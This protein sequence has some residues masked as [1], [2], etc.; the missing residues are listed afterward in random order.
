MA[1]NKKILIDI[2]ANTS[3]FVSEL[4]DVNRVLSNVSS[5]FS[6][7]SS[8]IDSGFTDL[9]QSAS[10][11]NRTLSSMESVLHKL[12]VEI[13]QLNTVS[14]NSAGAINNFSSATG[15]VSKNVSSANTALNAFMKNMSPNQI[16]QSVAAV[17]SM[18]NA[19]SRLGNILPPVGRAFQWNFAYDL[20]HLPG[21]MIGAASRSIGNTIRETQQLEGEIYDL[22]AFLGGVGG[23]ELIDFSKSL[24]FTGT[25]EELIDKGL[26]QLQHKILSVGQESTFTALQ[27]A[28]ATTEAAKAGVSI[29]EIA[30][31][32]GTALDAINLLAQNTGESLESSATSLSKLQN[33]FENSL[34]KTQIGFGQAA[35]SG[36]QFQII[37]DGLATADASASAT[38]S[39]LTQ[40]L[41]NVGGSAQ[42]L[43]MSFF[44]TVSLVA[45]MV[46]AFESAASAGTSLKY[47]FSALSG[48]RSVKAQGALKKLGLMDEYGQTVFFDEKGF[49]GL[50]FM[51]HQLREAFDDSSG[52]AVDVRN[53]LITDIFGQDALKAVSRLVSM[54]EE[55]TSEMLEMASQ[56]KANAEAGTQSAKEV[57][58][59]KNEGLDYDLE[60][61][62]GTIDSLGKTLA[63]PT[64]KPMSNVV[65]TAT[66]LANAAFDVIT[67]TKTIEQ[68]IQEYLG[69]EV[70]TKSL[71]PG[72]E[73]ILKMVVNYAGGLG[74]MLKAVEEQGWNMQT[75]GTAVA[76]L[77]G[78]PVADIEER[79]K[80][81]TQYFHQLYT[82]I[83]AFIIDL[84]DTIAMIGD[85]I[86]WAFDGIMKA[87]S[88][89]QTNWDSIV[90]GVKKFA[91]AWAIFQGIQI[92]S[93]I[94]ALTSGLATL[95][96]TIG[97][98][99]GLMAGF[100]GVMAGFTGFF[101]SIKT[102]FI[103]TFP[104]LLGGKNGLFFSAAWRAAFLKDMAV[105]AAR[106][107]TVLRGP[108]TPI[109]IAVGAFI[110]MF[111]QNTNG[112]RDFIM[113]RFG[114]IGT[115]LVQT[116]EMISSA[117][118]TSWDT[119]VKW[120]QDIGAMQF[121][122]GIANM[123]KGV[124]QILEGAIVVIGG[125]IKVIAGIFT[126]NFDL[127][128]SGAG[129]MFIGVGTAVMGVLRTIGGFFQGAVVGI[130]EI[131]NKVLEIL[132]M[133]S[134]QIDAVAV[135]A[136][137][138]DGKNVN[139][140]AFALGANTA[141]DYN[142][143]FING[144]DN[145]RAE[146]GKAAYATL[147]YV[148]GQAEEAVGIKSPSVD[149]MWMGVMW[150]QGLIDGILSN[151]NGVMGAINEVMNPLIDAK[152]NAEELFP[153]PVFTMPT[154][155][156]PV[157]YS[158]TVLPQT[159]QFASSGNMIPAQLSGYVESY[160]LDAFTTA[161]GG[162]YY[163]PGNMIPA[164][165]VDTVN[166]SNY[167][168]LKN[169]LLQS[170]KFYAKFGDEG[171]A[172]IDKMM[173][174]GYAY[175]SDLDR[176]GNPRMSVSNRS[177]VGNIHDRDPLKTL[178]NRM[179]YSDVQSYM[180]SGDF[181]LAQ[182]RVA[183]GL[184]RGQVL[185]D[186][187]ARQKMLG[188]P[189]F[190]KNSGVPIG[191]HG[192]GLSA[193]E[194]AENVD[195]NEKLAQ[196]S[197]SYF[198]RTGVTGVFSATRSEDAKGFR[199]SYNMG[200]E[201]IATRIGLTSDL[202]KFTTQVVK[203]TRTMNSFTK[204]VDETNKTFKVYDTG[205]GRQGYGTLSDELRKAG[206]FNKQLIDMGTVGA[207]YAIQQM[208]MNVGEGGAIKPDKYATDP[209]NFAE[210]I[211]RSDATKA[212][213]EP[214]KP[215]T[216]RNIVTT[217]TKRKLTPEEIN[218][219]NPDQ[220]FIPV[221]QIPQAATFDS[222]SNLHGY[223][224][225]DYDV[226]KSAKGFQMAYGE[227]GIKQRGLT[228]F[229]KQRPQAFKTLNEIGNRAATFLSMKRGK[230][231]PE[232]LVKYKEFLALDRRDRENYLQA[233][234]TAKDEMEAT[235]A[236]ASLTA[237][238]KKSRNQAS[239]GKLNRV[240]EPMTGTHSDV[241]GL[242]V[243]SFSDYASG[244][245]NVPEEMKQYTDPLIGSVNNAIFEAVANSPE[246]QKLPKEEQDRIIKAA[247]NMPLQSMALISDALQDGFIDSEELQNAYTYAGEDI[248][249]IR[250][251]IAEGRGPSADDKNL[252]YMPYMEGIATFARRED[253]SGELANS[254]FMGWDN[255][256]NVQFDGS[257]KKAW[258]AFTEGWDSESGAAP[259]SVMD[260]MGFDPATIE[261]IQTETSENGK[262]V[263][264]GLVSGVIEGLNSDEALKQ[265]LV[266]MFGD[267]GIMMEIIRGE[268]VMNSPSGLWRDEVGVNMML[269]LIDG[270][271]QETPAVHAAFSSILTATEKVDDKTKS[272]PIFRRLGGK[273]SGQFVA[274]FAGIGA[275]ITL[276]QRISDE[277]MK[278]ANVEQPSEQTILL[279]DKYFSFGGAMGD[280][281]NKGFGWYVREYEAD[282][283]EGITFHLGLAASFAAGTMKTAF[284]DVGKSAVDGIKAGIADPTKYE[285]LKAELEALA[286]KM[287]ADA[288]NA[289]NSSSPSK[290][291][292]EKVGNP[293]VEGIA[294]GI[295]KSSGVVSDA[296]ENATT[297]SAMYNAGIS[298]TA[299][300][301]A[302]NRAVSQ[303]NNYSYSYNL[304]VTTNQTPQVVKRSFAVMKSFKGDL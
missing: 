128:K 294:M 234:K 117:V 32:T 42:N 105:L 271:K 142:K 199:Y 25:D 177:S 136:F 100:K 31:P 10:T 232:D 18:S 222:I 6:T 83:E 51:T 153:T 159:S 171:I 273:A 28:Q 192:M 81:L 109:I 178:V 212:I 58:A 158:E 300:S 124:F 139:T 263:G 272:F 35:D 99:S 229:F 48:G 221:M 60:V 89:L 285:E 1:N 151:K 111:V 17:E 95:Y 165:L 71:V 302:A 110:A 76:A 245:Y 47:M 34:S 147:E 295:S 210:Q 296:L 50:D 30:G 197:L 64:L 211:A 63:M 130:V 287:V 149:A 101:S 217:F 292:A 207:Q 194:K 123:F 214:P 291:F 46:P 122:N 175:G 164:Q 186:P 303:N 281:F 250:N 87:V 267:G 162:E 167:N 146:A 277:L 140:K 200:D 240:G 74:V 246:F 115:Y 191:Y 27:I 15:N 301:G 9:S 137:F 55:Q 118:V 298:P 65:Q 7:V 90:D 269:G 161:R 37:V 218:A 145:G 94:I 119:T 266:K 44:E 257:G 268:L 96:T 248:A 226:S 282:K 270:I 79:A 67:E 19:F 289:I 231:T 264:D 23:V 224:T 77:L 54:T 236:D 84:P 97:G 187:L 121:V 88:W 181:D 247:Q 125:I 255:I 106:L 69:S 104:T 80:S 59:I 33:L 166:D 45:S 254:L 113:E 190:E 4:N 102:F 290:L 189:I 297:K 283:T 144:M 239:M 286:R 20:V 112:L 120:F 184:K 202:Y 293:I 274:G 201:K 52:M 70:I 237:E 173:N 304:G 91:M 198:T 244:A 238:E 203:S 85:S 78:T 227:R 141:V 13:K 152:N 16:Q 86:N 284:T 205:T 260:V 126:L 26:Q 53:R 14:N 56:L 98:F 73:G 262:K 196:G 265:L 57:A 251:M 2:Q 8:R 62:S 108:W 68:A 155:L 116:W 188:Q 49:K 183:L 40:A 259:L 169:A 220:A 82:T 179:G 168:Y 241:Y 156:P 12:V 114:H 225:D 253:I 150:T 174:A 180:D 107:V 280:S 230:L 61:L 131:I 163:S 148:Q 29:S 208:T 235:N 38:A 143:G 132:G 5:T 275:N 134:I 170:R 21:R 185:L 154:S 223:S 276:A 279:F 160:D 157:S 233:A 36:K 41:F 213:V 172:N 72:I 258:Q 66:A 219:R 249:T 92:V 3:K 43:N 209:Y 138:E 193:E 75:L 215:R 182:E 93:T 261:R 24:G 195:A 299:L 22:E 39:E 176:L 135:N 278:I 103:A 11:T 252:A 129:D 127:I 243:G 133:E 242:K 216:E 204:E 228:D 256:V 288:Q 206:T